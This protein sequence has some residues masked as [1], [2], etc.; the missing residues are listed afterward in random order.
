MPFSPPITVT[1]RS[2]T[3]FARMTIPPLTV[4]PTSVCAWRITSGP[5]TVPCRWTV[6]G[7]TAYAAPS[8][9]SDDRRDGDRGQRAAPAELAAV[10]GVLEPQAR[11]E[12]MRRR[13]A[14]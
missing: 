5:W 4:P 3:L 12:R 11:E 6:G 13:P 2:V 9:P 7:V 14:P 8:P 1:F 10:L